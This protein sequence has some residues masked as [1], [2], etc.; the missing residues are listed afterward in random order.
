MG[1]NVRMADHS[2]RVARLAHLPGLFQAKK[3]TLSAYRAGGLPLGV[4]G[5]S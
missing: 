1:R 4:L 5:R 3:L 2:P